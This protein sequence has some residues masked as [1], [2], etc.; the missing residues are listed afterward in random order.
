MTMNTGNR[1]ITA[2]SA[3]LFLLF[4]CSTT[5]LTHHS[6]GVAPPFCE[7]DLYGSKVAIYWDT[8]WRPDQKEIEL[9]ER[10]IAEGIDSFFKANGCIDTITITRAIGTKSITMCTDAEIAAVARSIGADK[11]I[12]MRF[13][14]LGPNLFL[15]LSPIL[16]ETKN[17]V[18]VRT[19]VIDSRNET[20]ETDTASH[21]YRGGPFML[22][23]TRSLHKDLRGTLEA[24][25]LR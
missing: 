21:W 3:A 1:R 10:I 22:L 16:W 4:G 18:L 8:A 24:L 12:V 20:I 23:G 7:S 9:R 11:A 19:K 13:E 5:R 17:E 15:Y 2:L 6:Q 14:E 25:F